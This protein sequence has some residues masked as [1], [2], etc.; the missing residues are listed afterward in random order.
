MPLAGHLFVSSKHQR[1]DNMKWLESREVI[2]FQ[3]FFQHNYHGEIKYRYLMLMLA[4]ITA[5]VVI[6]AL[7]VPTAITAYIVL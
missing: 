5:P 7:S 1:G 4:I 6:K 2:S 3:A